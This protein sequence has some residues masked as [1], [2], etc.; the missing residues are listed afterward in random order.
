MK[1]RSSILAIAITL[2]TAGA[3]AAAAAPQGALAEPPM[4]AI[5]AEPTVLTAQIRAAAK[6][7]RQDAKRYQRLMALVRA[8]Q[9]GVATIQR[10]ASVGGGAGMA[11]PEAGSDEMPMPNPPAATDGTTTTTSSGGGP[12]AQGLLAPSRVVGVAS[13]I[14]DDPRAIQAFVQALRANQAGIADLQASLLGPVALGFAPGTL[15]V[16]SVVAVEA[17]S[18]SGELT[19]Y[20]V[21]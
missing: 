4:G 2:T 3:A 5:A 10:W 6:G 1:L 8:P 19:I 17:Q 15:E 20:T 14:G 12:M 18:G 9:A 7:K 21:P 16:G 13:I 11:P